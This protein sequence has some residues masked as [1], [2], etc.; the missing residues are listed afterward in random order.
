M[1]GNRKCFFAVQ[2]E[3]H[4]V[5]M[6]SAT[7]IIIIMVAP[8]VMVFR[9]KKKNAFIEGLIITFFWLEKREVENAQESQKS[10]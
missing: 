8:L 4:L 6:S 3:L 2:I 5:L 7:A 10:L 1:K 9:W